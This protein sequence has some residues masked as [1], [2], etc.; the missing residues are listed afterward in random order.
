MQLG[1]ICTLLL[2]AGE[3]CDTMPLQCSLHL[4]SCRQ[5]KSGGVVYLGSPHSTTLALL[6]W[7]SSIKGTRASGS[8]A[9]IQ[10]AAPQDTL[11]SSCGMVLL[12][13]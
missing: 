4:Q 2:S 9:C 5:C 10:H 7:Y 6:C 3:H 13:A 12:Q 8:R 1:G 11:T